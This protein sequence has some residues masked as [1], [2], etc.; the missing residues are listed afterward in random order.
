MSSSNSV[1]GGLLGGLLGGKVTPLLYPS[2]NFM[3]NVVM[4]LLVNIAWYVISRSNAWGLINHLRFQGWIQGFFKGG[5]RDNSYIIYKNIYT[6]IIHII[7]LI[8]K[9]HVSTYCV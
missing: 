7:I 4:N 1:L 6:A 2:T 3:N 8:N 9:V 5:L